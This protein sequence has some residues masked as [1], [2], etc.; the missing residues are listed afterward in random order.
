MLGTV[1][2]YVSLLEHPQRSHFDV[3]SLSTPLAM[4]FV[5]K[6]SA[7]IRERWKR[8]AGDESILREA[9][10]GMTETHAVD[11]FTRGFQDDDFDIGGDRVF[12]GLPSP[13][14]EVMIVDFETGEPVELGCEGELAIRS[15]SVFDAYWRHPD[16]TA[17][18]FR[19]GW[20]H[21]GD[22][23]A[24]DERGLLYLL[25]RRKEML[26][27][28]GMSVFPSELELALSRHAAVAA[29]GVIGLPDDEHGEMP[30]ALVQ[31][32]PDADLREAD[33]VAWCRA[34]MASY[35]VPRVEIVQSLP[36]T[37]TGKVRKDILRETFTRRLAHGAS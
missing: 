16:E 10:F 11:T 7:T 19:D 12:L 9:G 6:M 15:P 21:T 22:I 20:F 31:L 1:D 36:L 5:T 24:F 8:F 23:A 14:T 35:K 17:A 4:S 28:R 33:L 25:G 30:L 13:E 34:R 27:V 37:T 2:N 18:A 26:K 32:R 3:S 29:C